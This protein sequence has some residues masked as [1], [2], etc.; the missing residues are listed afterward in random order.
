[1]YG[2]G[3]RMSKIGRKPIQIPDGVEVK[4]D[5]NQIFVKGQKGQ[6]TYT[7]YKYLIIV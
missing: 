3:E 1:M 4:L 7:L 6:L 5:N 2:R